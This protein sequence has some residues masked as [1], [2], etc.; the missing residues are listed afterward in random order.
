MAYEKTIWEDNKTP[1][2]AENLNKIEQGIEDAAKTGGILEDTI[3]KWPKDKPIPTGYVKVESNNGIETVVNENGTALKFPD[4]TMICYGSIVETVKITNAY[5][6]SYYAN[7][8]ILFAETFISTPTV[9]VTI[10][11]PSNIIIPAMYVVKTFS[12]GGFIQCAKSVASETITKN[13]IAIGRW[14]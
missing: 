3:V 5:G 8:D 12:V 13:Y 10:N 11:A 2:N 7:T 4:G 14:K 9:T 6:N 1:I